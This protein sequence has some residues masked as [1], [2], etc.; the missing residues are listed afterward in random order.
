VGTW[1][2]ELPSTVT[3]DHYN[4]IITIYEYKCTEIPQF[5]AGLDSQY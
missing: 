1:E 2:L 3:T 4:N 5:H